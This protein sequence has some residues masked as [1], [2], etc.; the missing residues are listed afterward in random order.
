MSAGGVL[1]RLRRLPRRVVQKI[2]GL[3]RDVRRVFYPHLWL[4]A[5][6][7]PSVFL[8]DT[9]PKRF[10]RF[11][12]A[13]QQERYET[14]VILGNG[15]SFA[16]IDDQAMEHFRSS[17]YL[18]I[19][20]N[21]SIYRFITRV[22]IWSDVETLESILGPESQVPKD[23]PHRP[24]YVVQAVLP[25]GKAFRDQILRWEREQSFAAFPKSK[26]FM[27]RTVLTAALHLCYLLGVKR[28]LLAGV[29]LDNR[30]YFF[31]NDQFD[32]SQPYELRSDT[33]LRTHFLGY[34]THRIVKETLESL[35]L[36][37]GVRIEYVGNSE[38]LKTVE[39][40]H[41]RETPHAF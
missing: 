18:T 3:Y 39:G 33:A 38:F 28:V 23:D 17:G 29:D 13:L 5:R 31:K 4:R 12:A 27:F 35:A 8:K 41:R 6:R 19:G 40:L 9:S 25:T 16:L 15:P 26:L 32:P 11:L 37:G 10:A 22:L 2:R 14:A 7:T 24:M 30:A 21:R 1:G 20:L 34:S 36:R